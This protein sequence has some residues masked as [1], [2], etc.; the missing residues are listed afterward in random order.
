MNEIEDFISN[1]PLF[2]T[3]DHQAGFSQDWDDKCFDDFL[4]YATADLA[5]AGVPFDGEDRQKIFE[6]WPFVRTTGYGQAVELAVKSLFDLEYTAADADAITQSMHAMMR[7][8][9]PET[10]Y[11]ELYGRAH[12]KWVITDFGGD[13]ITPLDVFSGE[14]YPPFFKYALR[15]GRG[16]I[17]T[18]T[19]KSQ[20]RELEKAM[21]WSVQSLADL[22][23]LMD[24]HTERAQAG[25]NMA[26]LKIALAYARPLDFADVTFLEAD[27]V[28]S[29]LLR[30]QEVEAKPLHDY[31][32]HRIIKR[33]EDFDVPVQIHTGY[34]E[35]NWCDFRRGDPAP[36]VP[37]F[38]K[39]RKVTFDLFH[40][41]WPYSEFI[42]AVA[43]E[44]PNVWIDLCWAWAINPVQ[45]ERI[46]DE[47]L[48]CV[49]SNKIFGFGADTDSPFPVVG[50]ALQ[51]RQGIAHVM[52]RKIASG[53]YDIDTAKFVARRIMHENACEV[54]RFAS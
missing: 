40:A 7:G 3:H 46:L 2:C 15:Y 45:M 53:E 5:T 17:L 50:Y 52:E 39:Y 9:S 38:Q 6:V 42:G 37:L 1:E 49:P 21:N 11:T 25:E 41:G 24:E 30:G 47:W 35:G 14:N 16:Q 26:A 51:A 34:L 43:K 19:G 44:F 29:A 22:D 4:A 18:V 8:R 31:L 54:F 12:I 28:L 27:R 48:S 20:I 33:A 32:A 36:L 10:I 13:T 23:R